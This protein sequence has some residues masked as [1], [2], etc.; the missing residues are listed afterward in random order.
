MRAIKRLYY[1]RTDEKNVFF[2]KSPGDKSNDR[3]DDLNALKDLEDAHL[4]NEIS[5]HS[6]IRIRFSNWL[7]LFCGCSSNKNLNILYKEGIS[8]VSNETNLIN[9][10]QKIRH[11][12][13]ILDASLLRSTYRKVQVKHSY[14]NIIDL[15]DVDMIYE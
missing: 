1:A 4:K 9:I 15:D 3:S 2:T 11:M 7:S 14:H 8:R 5:K 6:T 10:V 12:Q 13:A